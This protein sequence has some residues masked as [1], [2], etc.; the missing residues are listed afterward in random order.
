MTILEG[1]IKLLASRVMDDVPEGGGGPTGTVIPYG[2]SNHIFRDITEADR[3]GGNVSVMQVHAAVMTANAEPYMGANFILSM[4]P[5]DPNVSITLAK[6]NLFA[7]RT[8][9]AAAIAN[10]LIQGSEWSGYLLENHVQGQRN[11]QLFHRPGTAT[12][13]INRTLVLIYN[14]GLPSQLIQY[15]RVTKV[16]TETRTFTYNTGGGYVDYQASVSQ[17]DLS[18]ALRFNF[19]GSPPDRSFGRDTTKTL[20][21]DTTVADAAVYYGASPTTAAAAIGDVTVKVASIYTQLVPN[22]RT[23]TSALDQRPAATRSIVLAESPRRVEVA[24]APHSQRIKVGQENRGFN[25]VFL[26]KPLPE[27]GTVT[28]SFMV[29]GTWYALQDDGAGA[30]GGSGGGAGQLIYGTGSGSVTLPALPDPG[31]AIIIQWGERAAFTNRSAQ[32]PQVRAPEYCFVLEKEGYEAGT[33]VITWPS[34][35]SLRTA[36]AN[37]A[38]K[39]TG[40]AAG[41]I[42]APSSTVFLRPDHMID[43]GG[44]FN[45]AYQV[46]TEQVEILPA[47]GVDAGGFA[48]I[49][50]A[51]QPA[52]GTLGITWVTAREVSGTNGGTLSSASSSKTATTSQ[53]V[54]QVPRLIAEGKLN[55]TG[56]TGVGGNSIAKWFEPPFGYPG[57]SGVEYVP[58]LI[59]TVRSST[60]KSTFTRQSDQ[61]SSLRRLDLN[62]VTDDGVGG[63]INGLGTVAYASK[64]VS[65]R[66]VDFATS[67][68][69][70]KA[71]HESATEFENAVGGN[72]Q[73]T[74]GSN[75]QRG[76]E[77]GTITVGAAVLAGSSVVARYKVGTSTPT[78]ETMSFTPPEVVIDLCPYTTDRIVPGSVRFTWMGEVYED[79]EGVIYRGRSPT[80]T[81]FASGTADYAAGLARMDDYVVNGSPTAFALGSLWTQ[82]AAWRTASIF[83]RTQ[84]APIKPT[85]F[86]MTLLDVQG[87]ALTA[88]G[89]LSGNLTGAHMR[90]YFDYQ[91]GMAELQF[92]DYVDDATLTVA[93]KAEWWYNAADVGAVQAGKIW[94]PWPVDPTTLRYNAVAYFYLPLDADIIGLDPVRL[95][96]DGR[97]PMYR[98]GSYVVV[99]HTGV[100]PAATYTAPQTINCART[101]LS[102]VYLVGAD[103]QLIT[104]G[105]TPNLDAG[106]IA[107]T[108]VTGWVQPVTVKHRIEQ[109]ARV[110]DV[111][112]DGT[113]K[114]TKQLAHEFPVGSVVSSA[115]MAGNL[116]A[117]ALPVFDQQSWNGVTWSDITVGNQAPSTYND[118]AFPIVVTNA[119]AVTE[120]F[121]LR[122]LTGGTDVEVIG[123][124]VGNLGTFSRN[125]AIAPINHI[126]G[127]PYFTLAAAGWGAGWVPGNTLF[128]QTVGTYYP[129][130][131]IRATQPSEAIG[132]DYAFELTERGDVDRAPTNPVI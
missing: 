63:F 47:P 34:G 93:D 108:D 10:Y 97:V 53:A 16:T 17:L 31:S 96:P 18:D 80:T 83:M 6:C 69:S 84:A 90:G 118:G 37:A 81:G 121:A 116:R 126:A 55:V 127:A 101:R 91:F 30:F 132:T 85:G 43:P 102:R 86:V 120:R 9:I 105:Y 61:G 40:D 68:E 15:V 89:D 39:I 21:R 104:S 99:G 114:L 57:S 33:A 111:Q 79:F 26:L 125:T 58:A 73:S 56:A 64:T 52:A 24:A 82:K 59:T 131:V 129:M 66:M 20:I 98:V 87:N 95:P 74:G 128:L 23:E 112:I 7:R 38:G 35:G 22:S 65:L 54:Q 27:P 77:Y 12:P 88:T 32:G 92:G 46:S 62:T 107:V 113:L 94:R 29:L 71:D 49:T 44:Q 119:G 4:P 13:N 123:E 70:Y 28:I 48:T 130:A 115:I 72:G 3:A 103:G 100:V 78:N 45:I 60:S 2:G 42:D 106:T 19:P 8:E 51:Q 36:T 1:D 76:G 109:M 122:V 11:I 117:R 124:H 25:Y 14:E 75:T 50:L 41:E 67:T 110:A 5:T